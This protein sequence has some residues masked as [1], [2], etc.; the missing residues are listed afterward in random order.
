MLAAGISFDAGSD[1]ESPEEIAA[2]AKALCDES[3]ADLERRDRVLSELELAADGHLE[4]LREQEQLV[5]HRASL[6]TGARQLE[7]REAELSG[8]LASSEAKVRTEAR[9]LEAVIRH[10]GSIDKVAAISPRL[11]REKE[12]LQMIEQRQKGLQHLFDEAT[13]QVAEVSARL[14]QAEA[15][16]IDLVRLRHDSV[17]PLENL[18]KLQ[19]GLPAYRLDTTE[20]SKCDTQLAAIAQELKTSEAR[21]EFFKGSRDALKMQLDAAQQKY[22]ILTSA[23]DRKHGLLARL[24]EFAIGD[25]CPLCGAKHQSSEALTKSIDQQFQTVPLEIRNLAR[26]LEELRTRMQHADSG[27]WAATANVNGCRDKERELS[28][29]RY[30]LL[31]RTT[32]QERLSEEIQIELKEEL[33]EKAISERNASFV[34][35]TRHLEHVNQETTRLR[36]ERNRLQ[37]AITR[38]NAGITSENQSIAM[39]Q[40]N[41][42]E[43]E[44]SVQDLGF[45]E[46]ITLGDEITKSRTEAENQKE[47]IRKDK[48]KCENELATITRQWNAVR[49]AREKIKRDFDQSRN[50]LARV[51]EQMRRT[52]LL[53]KEVGIG[54]ND[55]EEEVK[56]LRE[57]LAERR[58][59]ITFAATV[60]EQYQWSATVAALS[61]QEQQLRAREQNLANDLARLN[62][63]RLQLKQAGEIA[64]NWTELLRDEVTKIIERRMQA[65]QPEIQRL[66]KAMVPSPYLFEDIP[67]ERTE[68][69]I[70]IGVKYRDQIRPPAEPKLFLSGAQANVLALA[71]FLSF[72]YSQTWSRLETVLLDDP[73]QH[74][75]DLDAVAFLDNLRAV[76]LGKR[77]QVIVS[78]CDQNLYLLMIR[79]F[80][81]IGKGGIRFRGFHFLRMVVMLQK[82]FMM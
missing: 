23:Q 48:A 24:R 70:E 14:A 71:I 79:K 69:G 22:N 75:D 80:R 41:I 2:A 18:K 12:Q 1:N 4:H 55:P 25:E 44:E 60:A 78:T 27:F 43:L 8:A 52:E 82:S 66:F 7:R 45:N 68:N 13:A 32:A 15:D 34:K 62:G 61:E 39:R 49:D 29:A 46:A 38:Y 17:A 56:T 50:K 74:L 63:D 42:R 19:Q 73:V 59:T 16:R 26:Q 9:K 67:M 72:A 37:A 11:T 35:I 51:T 65:H 76:A 53:C 10:L 58:Q 54:T 20:I 28:S 77:K 33:I 21:E 31:L 6:Q 40:A 5:N 57:N 81:V 64:G 47:A 36:E 30:E 3:V